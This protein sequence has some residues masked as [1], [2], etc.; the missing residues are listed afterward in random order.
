MISGFDRYFQIVR[1]FRDEALR[2]DRQLE[3]TQ[4]DIEMAFVD[5]S[6]IRQLME[7]YM[8]TI[9]NQ[10]LGIRLE[11]PFPK[12]SYQQAMETYGSDKPDLRYD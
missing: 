3:F 11:V 6:D 2:K 7:E 10:L 1:C 9:F 8:Q 12:I 5:E 4:V